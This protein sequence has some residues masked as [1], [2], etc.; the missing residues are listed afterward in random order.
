[1]EGLSGRT[2][3]NADQFAERSHEYSDANADEDKHTQRT[4]QYSHAHTDF[5]RGNLLVRL[6]CKYGL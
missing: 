3:A 6:E 5:R 1:V 4:D 2:H